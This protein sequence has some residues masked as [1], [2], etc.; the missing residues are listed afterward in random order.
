MVHKW[1]F[2]S[3]SSDVDSLTI[4]AILTLHY[5]AEWGSLGEKGWPDI[6]TTLNALPPDHSPLLSAKVLRANRKRIGSIRI[7]ASFLIES[8]SFDL[9]HTDGLSQFLFS[10]K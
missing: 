2:A 7:I 1:F 4:N 3:L 6:F 8:G 10:A 9:V 5:L